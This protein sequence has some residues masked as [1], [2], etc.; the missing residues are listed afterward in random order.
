[1]PPAIPID[2]LWNSIIKLFEWRHLYSIAQKVVDSA[3]RVT[4]TLLP[5]ATNAGAVDFNWCQAC[6]K[7]DHEISKTC[8]ATTIIYVFLALSISLVLLNKHV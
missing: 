6:R 7:Q 8:L 4:P 2:S 3:T 1:M 5:P